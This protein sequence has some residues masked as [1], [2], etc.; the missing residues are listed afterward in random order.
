MYILKSLINFTRMLEIVVAEE[1]ELVEEVSDI[2]ATER[3]HL[4]KW[5]DARKTDRLV[6]ER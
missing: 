4:R 2:D 6:E 5:E 1:I 3:I